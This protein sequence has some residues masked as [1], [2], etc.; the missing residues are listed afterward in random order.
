MALQR[1]V[2]SSE[3]L[4][5]I[6]AL[7]WR[8][9]TAEV[10]DLTPLFQQRGGTMRLK[11]IQSRALLELE[12]MGGL[13]G[14]IGA[15][16]GK[17]LIALL[18]A[19]AVGAERPLVLVPP[20]LKH[21]L[22]AVDIPRYLKHFTFKV[23]FVV[24]YSE[25]SAQKTADILEELAP[26]LVIC[27][28]A[29]NLKD[30]TSARTK[31]FLRF[32]HGHTAR[33]VFLSGTMT[34]KS[35]RDYAHLARLALGDASPLPHKWGALEDWCAALDPVVEV[36]AAP[37]ALRSLCNVHDHVDLRSTY[38]C[39]LV[40]SLGCV[41]TAESAIGTGLTIRARTPADPGRDARPH[42]E[43]SLLGRKS[44]RKLLPRDVGDHYVL[45]RAVNEALQKL[46]ETWTRPDG[47]EIEEATRFYQ[48][49]SQIAQGFYLRWAWP[50]GQID[51]EW[52]AARAEWHREMRAY[53]RDSSGA[54]R[55]TPGLVAAMAARQPEIFATWGAWD[56]VRDRKP[57]PTEIV[58]LSDYLVRDAA[59]WLEEGGIVW[60]AHPALGDAIAKASGA[61]FFGAG[62]DGIL[63]S[64]APGCCFAACRVTSF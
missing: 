14:P 7:P 59:Q 54:G 32:A 22:L 20:S 55:D 58:W 27:D 12:A 56:R 3:D 33:Y 23:P 46:R 18:A 13:L 50:K 8:D 64:S 35:L 19:D 24:S 11:P 28:E 29:H 53:L 16:H 49:A 6:I 48:I 31:R 5:R 41:A 39:R 30:K 52:L 44:S 61:P 15:G 1:G 42:S 9:D 47:E 2:P 17:T 45:P 21:Q 40:G 37:G 26:D 63:T 36:R 51:H 38:R 25:L 10:P 34:S 4:T 57:P 62:D 43:R 60:V